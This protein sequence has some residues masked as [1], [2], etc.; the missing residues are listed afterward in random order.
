MDK[1]AELFCCKRK[2]KK[3]ISGESWRSFDFSS[4]DQNLCHLVGAINLFYLFVFETR[5]GDQLTFLLSQ[6]WIDN[7]RSSKQCHIPVNTPVL[8]GK[9]C[10]LVNLIFYRNKAEKFKFKAKISWLQKTGNLQKKYLT[11]IISNLCLRRKKSYT[12]KR[13]KRWTPSGKALWR[14]HYWRLWWTP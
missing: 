4:G 13:N 9:R 1:N 8:R 2:R 6:S 14:Y 3:L 10:L 5:A 7:H 12:K 11:G